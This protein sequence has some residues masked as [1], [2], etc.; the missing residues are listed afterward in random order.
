MSENATTVLRLDLRDEFALN[1]FANLLSRF[2][3]LYLGLTVLLNPS[4]SELIREIVDKSES[5]YFRYPSMSEAPDWLRNAAGYRVGHP[6]VGHV[7]LGSTGFFE[8]VGELNPLTFIRKTIKAWRHENTEREKARLEH[9]A[10]LAQQGTDREK[11]H[12]EY[13][14]QLAKAGVERTK[15]LADLT[16]DTL[17]SLEGYKDPD[18]RRKARI[19]FSHVINEIG[20]DVDYIARHEKLV[21]IDIT[22]RGKS[23]PQS[24][25]AGT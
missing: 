9:E 6:R 13:Q 14:A 7:R 15:I 25:I 4:V 11:A 5:D 23:E 24:N 18:A 8:I 22:E 12:L 21:E 20:G 10:K 3:S 17:K 2:D 1:D 19:L 16:K